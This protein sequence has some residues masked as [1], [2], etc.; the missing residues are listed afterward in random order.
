MLLKYINLRHHFISSTSGGSIV[1]V[2]IYCSQISLQN[3]EIDCCLQFF[4]E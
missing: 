2:G 1:Q 3:F 4:R